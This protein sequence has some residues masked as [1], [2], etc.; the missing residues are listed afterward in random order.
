MFM[1]QIRALVIAAVSLVLL[2]GTVGAYAGQQTRVHLVVDQAIRTFNTT[3]VTVGEFLE[4]QNITLDE[5]DYLDPSP[6]TA[7]RDALVITINR[8]FPVLLQIDGAEPVE[9]LAPGVQMHQFVALYSEVTGIRYSYKAAWTQVIEPGDTIQLYVRQF[10]MEKRL[11]S[12]PFTT[13]RVET[14]TLPLGTEDIIVQGRVGTKS[15]TYEV[16]MEEEKEIKRTLI[17]E[18]IEELPVMRVVLVGTMVVVEE[19]VV[20]EDPNKMP[21]FEYTKVLTMR[22]YAYTCDYASTGKRPGDK[23]FG[24]CATGITAQYGVVAVD[25][26]VI[27][28]HTKLYIEGYGFAIAGDTGG[29]IKGEVIDLYMNTSAEAKAFGRQTRQVY[30]LADQNFDLGLDLYA[31]QS[32]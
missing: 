5:Y 25:P 10:V 19:E 7:L 9:A 24:I 11:E 1:K 12:I 6:E 28:L 18:V 23:G 16:E 8:A 20:E 26:K 17:S 13:T 29:A 22:A 27:P 3:M 30:I 21:E 14:D 32:R 31:N 15:L 2:S 4:E